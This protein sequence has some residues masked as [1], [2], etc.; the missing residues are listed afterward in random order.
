MLFVS[1]QTSKEGESGLGGTR[2][3]KVKFWLMTQPPGK[4]GKLQILSEERG[5]AQ[6]FRVLLILHLLCQ[7]SC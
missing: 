6:I 4:N 3:G 1:Y 7:A 5:W 2:Q